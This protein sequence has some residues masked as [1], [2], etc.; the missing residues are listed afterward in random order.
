MKLIGMKSLN[1]FVWT[2]ES[3]KDSYSGFFVSFTMQM[4]AT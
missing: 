3:G 2:W 1:A 4:D